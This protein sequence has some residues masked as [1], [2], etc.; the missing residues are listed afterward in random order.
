MKELFL[1]KTVTTTPT[2]NGTFKNC[3]THQL[4][5]IRKIQI[6]HLSVVA[7]KKITRED[8]QFALGSHYQDTPYDPFGKGTDEEKHRY[9]PIGLNRTQNA[10][11]ANCSDV[12]E[13]RAA[14]MWLLL[15]TNIHSICS[16][17]LPT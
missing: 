3:S 6:C 4:N 16:I 11:F 15:W 13:D 1:N 2:V 10:H 9:R 8:I 17:L 7:E 14:I 12:P 5:K